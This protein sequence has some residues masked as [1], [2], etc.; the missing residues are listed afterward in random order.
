M[1]S[2]IFLGEKFESKR[3]RNAYAFHN[4]GTLLSERERNITI[5]GPL[6][7]GFILGLILGIWNSSWFLFWASIIGVP[8]LLNLLNNSKSVKKSMEKKQ[9]NEFANKYE[10]FLFKTEKKLRD[11]ILKKFNKRYFTDEQ[12]SEH[13]TDLTNL[14]NHKLNLSLTDDDSVFILEQNEKEENFKLFNNEISKLHRKSAKNLA[15]LLIKLYPNTKFE[16]EEDYNF[17]D[18]EN[19][20]FEDEEDYNYILEQFCEFLDR[21]NIDYDRDELKQEL[22]S[23][24]KLLKAKE[25]EDKLSRDPN[26]RIS[27]D[28]IDH[29][30][31][32]EFEKLIGKLFRKAGYKVTVTKKT[33]DQGAD[34]I[35]EKDGIS[36]AIQTKR[37]S[38]NVG[39]KAVQEVVAAVKYYDCDK[40]MVITTGNFTKGALELASR[41]G[42][43]LIGRKGLDKLFDSIL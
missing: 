41:N 11:T 39:N 15:K 21:K 1:K 35:I 18:E 26:N 34:L 40:A 38:G 42:V 6:L 8:I 25:F 22:I 3:K 14:I 9:I 29:L 20:N 43:Q 5:G 24:Y 10:A 12:K 13:V 37:Y 4:K 33:G 36:T 19:T 7:G 30:S 27:V 31:G 32:F 2:V 23:E 17:E 16:D 28:K